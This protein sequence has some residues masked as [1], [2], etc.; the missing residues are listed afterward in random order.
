MQKY[1]TLI[2]AGTQITADELSML[3]TFFE[4]ITADN[5]GKVVSFDKW[6][7]YRLAYPVQKHD[8]GIYILVRYELPQE[9][10]E[11]A[12]K[13]L[14]TFF[15][16]KCNEIVMRNF[17]TKLKPDAPIT[18]KKPDPVDNGR[19]GGFDTFLKENKMET[20]LNSDV[21]TKP[22]S[23]E[24]HAKQAPAVTEIST[25]P[26]TETE[27]PTAETESST[28]TETKTEQTPDSEKE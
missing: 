11:K 2:L 17:T 9:G 26:N 5:K 18:Y 8:Y 12:F 28:V 23:T 4:K 15:K 14:G 7:K 22:A 16:I 25:P 24:T 3:E 1:E 13:D 27:T 21:A 19:K 10:A 20:F 6:G